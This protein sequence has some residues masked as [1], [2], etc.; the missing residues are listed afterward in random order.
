VSGGQRVHGESL[1]EHRPRFNGCEIGHCA[2][3]SWLGFLRRTLRRRRRRAKF[4]REIRSR[5]DFRTA[6]GRAAAPSDTTPVVVADA[7][8]ENVNTQVDALIESGVLCRLLALTELKFS[9]SM[10]EACGN[11]RHAS[12]RMSSIRRARPGARDN[13][14]SHVKTTVS[15]ASASATYI[16]SYA[17]RFSRNAQI[18]SKYGA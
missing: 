7:G 9:N 10:I 8:V 12:V 3:S 14:A 2:P 18:R 1:P 13:G 17:L 15:S 16:A 11:D 4:Y 5:P 6:Q